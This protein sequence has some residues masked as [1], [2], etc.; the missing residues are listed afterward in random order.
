MRIL[1][2]ISLLMA[3]LFTSCSVSKRSY[4][5]GYHVEWAFSKKKVESNRSSTAAPVVAESDPL[6]SEIA[7]A[8]SGSALDVGD[9]KRSLT[10]SS[11][12][13]GDKVIFKNGDIITAKVIEITDDKIKYKR[14]DNIEG[15]LFVVSKTAVHSIRYV[16]G[17]TDIIEP[18]AYNNNGTPNN[19][20][21]PG[22]ADN[23]Y[24]GVQKTHPK[25][26]AALLLTITGFYPLI[27]LGWILGLIFAVKAQKEIIANPKRYK[28]LKLARFVKF[29]TSVLLGLIA[30]ILILA[31]LGS[32]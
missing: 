31:I 14:C 29:F 11:D 4:R 5:K 19:G 30:L 2:C 6:E 3:L 12:T 23:D 16:N 24:K 1:A 15:P 18:P 27:I 28:G 9:I 8:S 26:I 32:L 25:A 22:N 21:T 7:L 10:L 17:V 13:C 20:Q